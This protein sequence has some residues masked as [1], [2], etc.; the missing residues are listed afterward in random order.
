MAYINQETLE[1]FI[2]IDELVKLTDDNN[3]GGVNTIILNEAINIASNEIDNYL[4][5]SYDI[6][7]FPNPLPE[8][9]TAIVCDIVIYNLY[10]RRFRLEMPESISKIYDNAIST[11]KRI[12]RGEIQVELPKKDQA[13]FIK[14]NKGQSDRIFKHRDLN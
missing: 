9:L 6:S 10:K 13:T 11:L 14:I 1:K 4:R 2:P 3:S 7:L 8:Q 5:D 12:A